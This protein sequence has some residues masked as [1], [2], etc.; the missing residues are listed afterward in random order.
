MIKFISPNGDSRRSLIDDRIAVLEHLRAARKALGETVP[1]GRNYVG[2]EAGYHADRDAFND[3][4]LR[5]EELI[6]IIEVEAEA[7][8]N[9]P[10]RP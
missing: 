3:R 2:D 7:I 5:I 8:L 10:G 4:A 6:T 9:L 1:H